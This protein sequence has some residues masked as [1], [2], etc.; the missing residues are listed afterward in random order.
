MK[1]SSGIRTLRLT[2]V[3]Q[4][5]QNKLKALPYGGKMPSIR[6]I[7]KET[8]AGRLTVAHALD[9]LRKERMIRID[10]CSGI[11]RIKEAEEDGEIRLIHFQQS[12]LRLGSFVDVL[13]QELVG[14]A[15]SDGRSLVVE[16]AG[17]RTPENIAQE[18][19]EDN[20]SSCILYG[21][22]Q[23]DFMRY[24]KHRL[25]LCLELLPRHTDRE[26]VA[27]RD[28]P[29]MTVVQ[30]NY[31]LKLGYRRIGC[32]HYGGKDAYLY[33]IQMLRLLD[34]YRIMAE[35]GLKVEP[36]WVFLCSNRY[37]NLDAGMKK[38]M[39]SHPRPEA[40]IVTGGA[41]PFLYAWCRKNHVRIGSDLAV[42]SAD[43][44]NTDL[45]PETTTVTNNP[46]EIAASFWEM[47]RE[48]ERGEN[49]ESR[50][51]KLSIRTGR[52]V[53]GKIRPE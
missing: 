20:I 18:L 47:F 49:V 30:M 10:R 9:A 26:S 31:L 14:L 44:V 46:K 25:S 51:T 33:P 43:D 27:M 1:K 28:S 38:M 5:L 42:F 23:P 7:M 6:A 52:T 17:Q 45:K 35:N 41:L 11:Y 15:E 34:Y 12:E 37:G 50:F 16:N 22:P 21:A 24:L 2:R 32:L 40:L 48:A 4:Y 39:S 13:F 8:G 29:D 3:T 19:A 36:D 53:P